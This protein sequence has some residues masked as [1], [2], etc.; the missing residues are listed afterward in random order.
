MVR[1]LRDVSSK[2]ESEAAEEGDNE[3]NLLL[4]GDIGVWTHRKGKAALRHEVAELR[5][6]PRE[7]RWEVNPWVT[8]LSSR[9]RGISRVVVRGRRSRGCNT[10]E[11]AFDTNQAA[12]E[13]AD[14]VKEFPKGGFFFFELVDR[15]LELWIQG[16]GLT[17]AAGNW[18]HGC[19]PDGGL[20]G[21][22]KGVLIM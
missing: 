19:G 1:V 21:L 13:G 6:F 11:A 12:A 8:D 22:D 18:S 7:L 15:W 5:N 3:E 9:N 10:R 17:G 2:I 16:F 20:S 14:C 4:V